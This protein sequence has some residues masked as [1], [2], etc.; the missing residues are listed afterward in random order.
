MNVQTLQSDVI[1][2]LHNTVANQITNFNGLVN[3]AAR[4]VLL[5][6]DPQ[7]TKR[8]LPITGAVYQSV[9]DYAAPTDLKGN[10]VIDIFPQ[11]NRQLWDQYSQIYNETFDTWKAWGFQENFTVLFN[12]ALKTLR[13]TAPQA[14]PTSLLNNADAVSSNGT[15][16]TGGTASNIQT[17][18]VTFAANNGSI[19]FNLGSGSVGS[20]GYVENST[21]TVV[22]LSSLLNQGTLFL[23]VFL[24]TASDFTN[25]KLRWG[26]SSANYYE[27]T[28]TVTQSNTVFQNGWNLLAFPWSGASVTGSPSASAINYIRVSY[29]YDG[30][31]QTAVRLNEIFGSLGMILNIEY[32]SKYL[33]RNP[34]TGAFQETVTDG[35][36]LI[37]LDTESYN[38]LVYQVCLLAMQ[39]QQGLDA[40]FYD[41]PYFQALYDKCLA[42]YNEL[43]R[44]EVITPLSSYYTM[45]IPRRQTGPR[46]RNW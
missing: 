26:S 17:D 40:M 36:T 29:T 27:V 13:L 30:T 33:F 21:M 7:E 28:T 4:Q 5:D 32:Y 1:G 6:V 12:S 39:Q 34:S 41:G 20:V 9:Y 10:R 35:T 23:Y 2:T 8:I 25:V 46:V 37:N 44:S 16:A 38:L 19:S 43:Y 18:N 31:A 14:P 3:R 45:T 11:V 24:P 42:R 22:N 15:W